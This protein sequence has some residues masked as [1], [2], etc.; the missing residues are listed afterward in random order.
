MIDTHCHLTF[1]EFAGRIPEILSA[2][3]AEGVTGSITVSTTTSDA[4]ASLAVAK[5]Y[6]TNGVY[7]SA[8]VHP[9][10]A[11]QP[12]NWA[13]M[14]A[15][16][17]DKRC[18]AFGELGLD[19]HYDHP[20]LA[21]QQKVLLQQLQ[22]ICDSRIAKPVIVHCREA[23][24]N[25]LPI[26]RDTGIPSERFVFHCFTGVVAD[27]RAV[28][29]FGANISFTGIVTFKNATEIQEAARLVPS[30][31]IMIETDAP[32]LTPEPFRKVRPNEPRYAIHTAKFIAALRRTSWP[33]FHSSI[34]ANTSRFFGI[35][36]D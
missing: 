3:S 25:L 35:P 18:V 8:G 24:A 16:A 9:L 14:L 36:A 2:A 5:Q 21:L 19:K 34:N 26:I 11:D 4:L 29:D 1:P 12:C 13:D 15:A 20:A 23:F 33:E 7:C 28:L 17:S 32:F 31:R 30:D 27:A 10:Y 6:A 22:V